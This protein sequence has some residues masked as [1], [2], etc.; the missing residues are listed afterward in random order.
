MM[1]EEDCK[2][3]KI[4]SIIGSGNNDVGNDMDRKAWFER[5]VGGCVA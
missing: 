5:A 3:K 1:H 4:E 2:R